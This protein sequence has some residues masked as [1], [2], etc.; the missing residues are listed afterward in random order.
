MQIGNIEHMIH[1]GNQVERTR[2]KLP[3]GHGRGGV[4]VETEVRKKYRGEEGEKGDILKTPDNVNFGKERFLKTTHNTKF[5]NLAEDPI[6]QLEI[7]KTHDLKLHIKHY[8][9]DHKIMKS[10]DEHAQKYGV[11]KDEG[12]NNA[13]PDNW[14][15]G[16]YEPM[17]KK[18]NPN[19]T[20]GDHFPAHDGIYTETQ[21]ERFDNLKSTGPVTRVKTHYTERHGGKTPD[22]KADQDFFGHNYWKGKN[23]HRFLINPDTKTN[24]QYHTGYNETLKTG[25]IGDKPHFGKDDATKEY[26]YQYHEGYYYTDNK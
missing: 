18:F 14:I 9:K 10:K 3:Y 24:T 15:R 16:K 8:G 11:P 5:T 2:P 19:T 26:L 1:K 25:Q 13:K 20:K 12:E 23:G 17:G 6:T 21:N 4:S 7:D 22:V